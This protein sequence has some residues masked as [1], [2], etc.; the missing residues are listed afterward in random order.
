MR[1]ELIENTAFLRYYEKWQ[2][3]PTSVVF[4]AISEIFRDHG[5]LDEA[6]KIAKEGLKHHPQLVSGQ[7]ALAKAYLAKG[8]MLLARQYAQSVLERMPDNEEARRI[9]TMNG[10]RLPDVSKVPSPGTTLVT[11]SNVRM[12]LTGFEDEEITEE[13]PIVPIDMDDPIMKACPPEGTDAS[14]QEAED[15]EDQEP[16]SVADSDAWHTMT[17]ADI[18]KKQ[19]H[20]ERA[21]R[22]YKKILEKDPDNKDAIEALKG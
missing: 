21:R 9:L 11:A 20:F 2:K 15:G 17:M 22:I 16:S 12:E 14:P 8:E 10:H 5:M 6:V 7:I 18:L 3:D 19:G 4:A 13:M 1:P